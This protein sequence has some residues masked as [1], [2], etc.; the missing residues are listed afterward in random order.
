MLAVYRDIRSGKITEW[1][2]LDPYL[3]RGLTYPDMQHLRKELQFAPT[4]ASKLQAMNTASRLFAGSGILGN[5]LGELNWNR[6]LTDRWQKK[7]EAKED[8]TVLIRDFPGNKENM[9]TIQAINDYTVNVWSG[10]KDLLTG[11]TAAQAE[12]AKPDHGNLP[13]I[14]T[15]AEA[16][17]LP[18]GT[19]VVLVRPGFPD[20][21]M[22][23]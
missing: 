19:Y 14:T 5:Q 3:G 18:K 10:A 11:L 4:G 21:L 20:E 8:P 9:L 23:R 7:V 15:V 2:Q 12:M 17:K 6:D 1:T 22:V 16:Q 13:K